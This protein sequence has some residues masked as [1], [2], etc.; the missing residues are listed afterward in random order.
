M[1][2]NFNRR[3]EVA[4]PVEDPTLHAPLL[5]LLQACLADNRQAWELSA[6]G[7]YARRHPG[8]AP[9]LGTQQLLLGDPWGMVHAARHRGTPAL[10]EVFG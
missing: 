9:A 10:G 2:R 7:V 8:D 4:V 6:D 5:S 1:P 3:V